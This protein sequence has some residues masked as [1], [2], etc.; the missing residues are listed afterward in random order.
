MHSVYVIYFTESKKYKI[1]QISN[2]LQFFE[3]EAMFYAK[4][5]SLQL[6]LH[7]A[8]SIKIN[9]IYEQFCCIIQKEEADN[10]LLQ[11]KKRNVFHKISSKK[12]SQIN[13]L[14]NNFCV[15]PL[16]CQIIV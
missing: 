5:F 16:V 6:Q 15:G 8:I 7:F 4:K 10:D 13:F 12:L 11:N 9:L 2:K 1:L 14:D 3:G